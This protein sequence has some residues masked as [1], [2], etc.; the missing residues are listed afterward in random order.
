MA[1]RDSAPSQRRLF[2]Y[3]ASS[4]ESAELKLGRIGPYLVDTNQL[5]NP[6]MV[7]KRER[8]SLWGLPKIGVG[9]KPVDGGHYILSRE[10]KGA[11]LAEEPDAADLLR[12]FIGSRQFINGEERWLLFPALASPSRLRTLPGV[13]S[14]YPQGQ[15]FFGNTKPEKLGKSLAAQP[16]EFHVS[17]VPESDFLVIPET[18]SERRE[19]VPIGYLK[20][21]TIPSNA[22]LVVQKR[23]PA[24]FCLAD[25]VN[26]YGLAAPCWWPF[27]E[28]VPLFEWPCLQ[29]LS[30]TAQGSGSLETGSR[31]PRLFLMP[32]L[33]IRVLR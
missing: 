31:W 10:E 26:A 14:P 30:A 20:P 28:S 3:K 7:V 9:T 15:E 6:H 23:N 5:N 12:P 19:Y 11:F 25:F 1:D 8:K 32:V 22:L 21:P 13:I 29:H 18:S 17:L 24:T 27:G 16:T 2:T 4:D 33:P